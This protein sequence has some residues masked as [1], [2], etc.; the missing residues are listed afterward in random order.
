MS[1]R[2]VRE[3]RTSLSRPPRSHGL[4]SVLLSLDEV[5]AIG[6]P[7][8]FSDHGE[9][10]MY[11]DGELYDLRG[12]DLR[13]AGAMRKPGSRPPALPHRILEDGV[14]IEYGWRHVAECGCPYCWRRA[15]DDP[16]EQAVA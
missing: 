9:H 11:L 10:L 6:L 8:Y 4:S 12:D 15:H 5:Q 16:S 2:M 1:T 14:G 3:T 7:A 13:T